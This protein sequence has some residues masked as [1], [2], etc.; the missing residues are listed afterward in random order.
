MSRKWTQ[1]EARAGGSVEPSSVNDELR[2]Q[3]SSITTLDRDQVPPETVDT[4]RLVDYAVHRVYHEPRWPTANGEQT[5]K[6]TSVASRMFECITVQNDPGTWKAASSDVSLAS[7]KGGHLFLEWSGN[8]LVFPMFARTL[9]TE[10]PY[11]PKYLGLR[12]L[13]NGVLFHE[14]RGPA[15]HECWRVFGGQILPPGELTVSFQYRT[16]PAGGDDPIL[17]TTGAEVAQFHLYSM[18]YLAVGRFR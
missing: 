16:T 15:Y 10:Y 12:M 4:T 9:N 5:T 14:A 1:R 13:V 17:T 6:S 7:F 8:A 18:K 11:Q 3:Q 2:A